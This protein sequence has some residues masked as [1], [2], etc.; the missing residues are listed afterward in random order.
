MKPIHLLRPESGILKVGK[1]DYFLKDSVL[2]IASPVGFLTIKSNIFLFKF[3]NLV[4]TFLKTYF[5]ES[6]VDEIFDDYGVVRPTLSI[7]LI[8][9]Q[10]EYCNILCKYVPF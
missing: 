2:R 5:V 8:K 4:T 10:Y 6:M 1:V 7:R 9:L 3:T